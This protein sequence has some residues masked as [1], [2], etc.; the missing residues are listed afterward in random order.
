V[1]YAI[2]SDIHSNLEAFQV[3]NKFIETENIDKR[4]FLGD[5]VGYGANPNECIELLR[6][7]ADI[8]LGG[9]RNNTTIKKTDISCF[10]EYAKAA[11]LWT[12]KVL[13]QENKNYLAALP[14]IDTFKEITIAHS[15]PWEPSVWHYIVNIRDARNN[16]EYFD[17]Q[18]C[19]IG[20]SHHPVTIS[21]LS[22]GTL[23]VSRNQLVSL[24]EESR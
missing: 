10:N 15:S 9:N 7:S 4:I 21:R 22:D 8:V 16:F 17:T 2:F 23:K 18:L 11:I 19:F 14:V 5:I 20:H 12:R 1:R 3:I 24:N 6:K 13:S